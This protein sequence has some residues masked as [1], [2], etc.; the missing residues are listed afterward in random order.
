MAPAPWDSRTWASCIF[1]CTIG[2]LEASAFDF[3]R[4]RVDLEVKKNQDYLFASL[5]V[6]LGREMVGIGGE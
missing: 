5:S 2:S 4:E 6:F 1:L 3:S